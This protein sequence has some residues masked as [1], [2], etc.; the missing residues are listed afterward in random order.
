MKK[1]LTIAIGIT[2]FLLSSCSIQTEFRIPQNLPPNIIASEPA[3]FYDLVTLEKVDEILGTKVEEGAAAFYQDRF[4]SVVVYVG[5]F[6]STLKSRM[7]F[8]GIAL[9]NIFS[10]KKYAESIG[11]GVIEIEK[12][13]EKLCILWD[14]FYV[15]V[16]KGDEEL[17]K[18]I[19]KIYINIFSNY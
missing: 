9:K 12:K 15:I 17:I 4:K 11:G 2:I 19:F 18:K 16:I 8:E 14:K 7:F 1:L 13:S 6:N 3:E 5:F 10:L